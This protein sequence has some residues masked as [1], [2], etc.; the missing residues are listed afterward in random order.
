MNRVPAGRLLCL[1]A[2]ASLLFLDGSIL[3][4]ATSQVGKKSPAGVS[5]RSASTQAP[6]APAARVKTA[7]PQKGKQGGTQKAK[8]KDRQRSD[9][10]YHVVRKG[11]TLF[12]ISRAYHVSVESLIKANALSRPSALR[13]GQRLFI[14]GVQQARKVEPFRPLTGKQRVEIAE[15]LEVENEGEEGAESP[16]GAPAQGF[17]L[18][19]DPLKGE[20]AASSAEEKLGERESSAQ[21]SSEVAALP[22]SDLPS[23]AL[24]P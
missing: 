6:A 14:P 17:Y 4:A 3:T 18:A 1:L 5:G 10:L 2:G 12:G 11:Q 13:I 23:P 9:G 24:S 15:V 22:S 7:P 20:K 21:P 19:A 8:P 16:A